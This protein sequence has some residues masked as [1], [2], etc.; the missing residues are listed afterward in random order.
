MI[1]NREVH[2]N[3]L[4]QNFIGE[5]GCPL[6]K[7]ATVKPNSSFS[8]FNT[9]HFNIMVGNQIAITQKTVYFNV[10]AIKTIFGTR[11]T[12]TIKKWYPLKDSNLGLWRG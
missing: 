9:C 6:R 10:A 5:V 11:N 2:I 12:V 7:T 3:K 1:Q 4:V 8:S